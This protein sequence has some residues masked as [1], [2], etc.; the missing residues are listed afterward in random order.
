VEEDVAE[1]HVAEAGA[2]QTDVLEGRPSHVLVGELS[3]VPSLT[4]RS[5]PAVRG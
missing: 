2:G 4:H 5:A 3:H 1:V